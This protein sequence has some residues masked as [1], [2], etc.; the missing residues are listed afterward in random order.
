VLPATVEP[1]VLRATTSA[2][3]QVVGQVAVSTC[4][5]I[6]AVTLDPAG[7]KAP[8]GVVDAILDADQVV[9]GPGSLFTSVLAAAV[10]DDIRAAIAETTAQRIYVC[11]LRAEGAETRD[12]DVVRHIEAVQAHGVEPDVVLVHAADGTA[13]PAGAGAA[14][15]RVV[16]ADLAR[17]HG[18]AHDSVKLGAALADLAASAP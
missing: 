8:D 14:G 16:T 6:E 5:D 3:T 2:G 1:V 11:N 7:V 15:I 18:L 10:V 17:P 4:V 9:L 13:G 12:Y